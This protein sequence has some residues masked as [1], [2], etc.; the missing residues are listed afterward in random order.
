MNI[1]PMRW[2][3]VAS[4]V[5]IESELFGDTAWSAGQFWSELAHVPDTRRYVVA[6]DDDGVLL[7]YAGV[8]VMKPTADVQTIAVAKQAQR[9][10][11]GGALLDALLLA[12][13]EYGCT[14][15]MLEVRAGNASA[16]EL[17]R[18]RGF[19]QL[20][21]RRGY[22]GPGEDALIMRLRPV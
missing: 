18:A 10:G 11:V 2:W 9:R 14:E 13:R 3:D 20:A 7:G 5:T 21:V 22:Y 17:Y 4:L 12:A 8:Y 1:A 15:M 16:I 6:R 19:E